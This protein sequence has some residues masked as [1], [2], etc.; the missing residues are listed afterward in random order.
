MQFH[1]ITL[2]AALSTVGLGVSLVLVGSH[3]S[4]TKIIRDMGIAVIA[5]GCGTLLR[6]ADPR[7]GYD[8]SFAL[9]TLAYLALAL[10]VLV[11]ARLWTGQT[12][13]TRSL[14]ALGVAGAIGALWGL[15]DASNSYN[16]IAAVHLLIA[17]AYGASVPR[18]F[19]LVSAGSRLPVM[20]MTIC[21]GLAALLNGVQSARLL[22]FGQ[23]GI[24][25]ASNVWLA[26]WFFGGL[27]M[28][29]FGAV[30]MVMFVLSTLHA[31]LENIAMTDPLTHTLNRRGLDQRIAS[32][33]HDAALSAQARNVGVMVIDIDNFKQINDRLGHVR[34]DEV[35]AQAARRLQGVLRP[36]D[37]IARTGGEE[38]LVLIDRADEPLMRELAERLRTAICA[39]PFLPIDGSECAV[40]VSVGFSMVNPANDTIAHAIKS[41]DL[42]M[43]AAKREG[44]NRVVAYALDDKPLAA[45]AQTLSKL[46]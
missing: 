9:T 12:P 1:A 27:W 10:W 39:S 11:A 40:A 18:S 7:A 28:M 21:C 26:T 2:L 33:A 13:P 6:A 24:E 34:G 22:S 4:R 23:Y 30:S 37:A 25:A 17:C 45:A 41:A 38:F 3:L 35:L 19:A 5:S 20:V 44:K 36:H 42:A 29:T 31:E 43:Y 16:A 8:F 15:F 32:L 46:T 14:A